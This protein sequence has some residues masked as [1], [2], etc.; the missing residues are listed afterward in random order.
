MNFKSFFQ[1]YGIHFIAVA[2]FLITAVV[3]FSPQFD[4]YG[5]KQHDIKEFKGMS[6][7]IVHHREKTG[8]EPLWTNSMFGGMPATQISV[9]HSGNIF[10][11]A[12]IALIKMFSAPAGIFI[13]H[14]IGF[15]IMALLLRIKP[16][17]GIIGAFA[18]AFSSY[19]IVIMQAGHNSKAMAVAFIPAVLGAFIYAFRTNWKLGAL[20]SAIFMCIEISMNHFQVT[21]YLGF[22]LFGL[23]IFFLIEAIQKKELKNFILATGGIIAGYLIALFIN[24]G[25]I[26]MTNDYA[27]HTI[28]G[29]NDLSIKP[30]GTPFDEVQTGLDKDYI[31]NW[32]Y[33][34][35][36][37]FT[38]ISPYVKGSHNSIEIGNTNFAETVENM[39]F[40]RDEM[41]AIM[42]N[43]LYFGEQPITSG[44]VYLGIIVVFLALLGMVFLKDRMRWV[45]LAVAVLALMLSWG[46]NFMGLTDFFID[47]I[48]GYNKFRTVTIILVLLELIAPVLA[49]L[50]LQKFYENREE[51]KSE[52]K[53]FLIVS[54]AFF[55]FLVGLKVVGIDKTYGSER[56]RDSYSEEGIAQSVTEQL[57]NSDPAQF[58]Q[59][60]NIDLNDP[61]QFKR[62]VDSQVESQMSSF[63]NIQK[64]RKE[65]A[66]QSYTRSIVFALLA[67]GLLALFFYTAVPSLAILIGI[68]VLIVADLAMVDTNYLGK[69]EAQ[70]GDFIH[71]APK[72]EGEYPLSPIDADIA[73]MDA[74]LSENPSLKSKIDQGAKL[75]NEKA[76]ELDY[77]GADKSRVINDYKFAALNE[78]TNYRVF[79]FD[80]GFGSS[81]TSYYHKS[82]GGYHG[83]KLR[84]IQNL[85]EFQL[86][87]S[88]N[89]VLNM[90]NVKYFIQKGQ[91]RANPG[92]LGPVWLVEK[93][94]TVKSANDEIRALGGRFDVSNA[95]PGELLI[96]GE[97]KASQSVYGSEVMKYVLSGTDTLDVNLTNGLP[98]GATAYMVVDTNGVTNLVPEQ[99][100]QLDVTNSFKKLV[101]IKLFEKFEA[102]KEAV[103]LSDFASKLSQKKFSGKGT[104]KMKSY[105]PNKLVYSADLSG[106]QFAVFS[107]MY[108][109]DGWTAKVDGKEVEIL[110]VDY[111]L[112]G[113][114]LKGGKYEVVFEYNL[115]KYRTSYLTSLVLSILLLGLTIFMLYKNSTNKKS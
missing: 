9:V 3:Y 47:N 69:R 66:S 71:W 14:L 53:K 96:N 10:N 50:L 39:D 67:I 2:L 13:L 51:L 36:E 93:I 109:P 32:S 68:G 110:K 17:I 41:N 97:K 58:K 90:L 16:I 24:Y 62:V 74:E 115:P 112:R 33:G 34:V 11:N 72:P 98:E 107:E 77:S 48:P 84:S 78:C 37:S 113:L 4:G 25:I 20:F 22:L 92:A 102:G 30:D 80:G 55:V 5:L 76:E 61:T 23:G 89:E 114:E 99:T 12:V 63:T 52:S 6:N 7:E 46:K 81:R 87:R 28:R 56:E 54:G 31:T 60:Y 86:S 100:I 75:G 49:I 27:K 38:L 101:A 57:L 45:F 43:Q 104:I 94:N 21:Y 8:E 19:E 85:M 95:G 111:A 91:M 18:F 42:N 106:K 1:K 26:S 15:Y 79:D 59:Q 44:P 82:L 65:V 35:D 73:I 108:Y 83:A 64:V 88:N 40:N 29:A 70:N 103:M 105:A